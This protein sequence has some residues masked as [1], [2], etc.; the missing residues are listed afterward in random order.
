[1]NMELADNLLTT[2]NIPL[3]G[4]KRARVEKVEMDV[5]QSSNSLWL[6]K[7]PE[8][9]GEHLARAQH[10]EVVGN[11]RIAAV[12][13]GPG[14][15]KEKVMSVRLDGDGKRKATSTGDLILEEEVPIPVD[16]S[17]EDT[18]I[19][20]NGKDDVRMVGPPAGFCKYFHCSLLHFIT[21]VGVVDVIGGCIL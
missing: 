19:V 6:V 8:F 7:V 17:M 3:P 16:Y 10:N 5:P 2:G 11:L 18:N 1:M 9:L 21:F 12:S 14:K 15:P 13:K 4:R 20:G